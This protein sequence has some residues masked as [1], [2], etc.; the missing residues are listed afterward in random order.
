MGFL[1]ADDRPGEDLDAA[2][3]SLHET[4]T[5]LCKTP[6]LHLIQAGF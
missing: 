5:D 2:L 4:P 6:V 3:A 1:V